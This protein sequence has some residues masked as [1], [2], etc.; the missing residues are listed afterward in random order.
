[1]TRRNKSKISKVND[2]S[3]YGKTPLESWTGTVVSYDPQ[4]DQLEGGW[5]RRY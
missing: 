3:Q 2:R 5:G 1:M 4:K